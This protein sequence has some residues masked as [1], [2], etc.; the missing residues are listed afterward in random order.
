[1]VD[2]L[3]DVSRIVRGKITLKKES[4]EFVALAEKVVESARLLADK[5]MHQLAVQLPGQAVWLEGDPVR[6]SQVLLNLI[7]NA[8]KYTP[9]GGRIELTAQ[10]AGGEL[11]VQVRDN[12]MGI[13]SELLPRVFDLFQQDDRT[14]DRAQGGLGLGLT[15]VQQLVEKHGGRVE[16]RSAGPGKGSTFTLRL[17]I[18]TAPPASPVHGARVM[19]NPVAEINILVVDDDAA[20]AESMSVLLDMVGYRVRVAHTGLEALETIPGFMPQV[21]LLDIG[22]KGMDGFETAKRLRALPEGR[23]IFLVALTGYADAK[24]K[25]HALASGCSEFMA[26]PVQPKALCQLLAQY[27]VA[28]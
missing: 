23:D 11:E 5:K 19:R 24:T 17:P 4:V 16:A 9:E 25:A 15:L 3:L 27:N 12:G 20:V 26:K 13:V 10:V 2:D 28:P 18:G 7:D 22:L 8:I 1:M 14:L 21:V 6:L